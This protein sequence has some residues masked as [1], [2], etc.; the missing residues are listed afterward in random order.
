VISTIKKY[1]LESFSER[2]S[3]SNI[4]EIRRKS[5][6]GGWATVGEQ[7]RNYTAHCLLYSLSTLLCLFF[8][9]TSFVNCR[10]LKLSSRLNLFVLC[11]VHFPATETVR[12]L[13]FRVGLNRKPPCCDLL[14]RLANS[15]CCAQDINLASIISFCDTFPNCF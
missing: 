11:C 8:S 1:T 5:V 12:R 14:I 13:S 15:S 7:K 2:I 9:F 3:V 10:G 6:L 4:V